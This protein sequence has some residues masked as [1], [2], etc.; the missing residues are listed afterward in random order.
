MTGIGIAESSV[1]LANGIADGNWV[2]AG[3][4]GAGVGLEVLSMVIDP[5]GTVASYG[6]GWLME[7]VQ[8]LKEALDWLVGDPPVIRSFSET[9]GNV[10]AEV[11][12][13][14]EELGGQ[15]APGW[16]GAAA[17]AFRGA[18]A[19]TA[20]AIAGA[21]VLAEGVG[22]G[23]MVGPGHAGDRRAGH[24]GHLADVLADRGPGAQVGQDDLER[25]AAH[26][27][28]GRQ[29]GR[30]HA[31]A[32]PTRPPRRHPRQSGRPECAERPRA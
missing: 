17:Q 14:A 21:G 18:N 7:H 2:E 12:A 30:D 15:D 31:E 20:D 3:L 1:D 9:W 24:H 23:V 13:V 27:L 29:A 5:V 16:E 10:A 28:G 32:R 8:P 4:G 11:R 26:P 19:E 25:R 6:V 22:I